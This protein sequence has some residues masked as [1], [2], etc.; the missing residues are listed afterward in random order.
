MTEHTLA[1]GEPAAP[2]RPAL[3]GGPWKAFQISQ[4]TAFWGVDIHWAATT[5]KELKGTVA[6]QENL[7]FQN[8]IFCF[9]TS[10]PVA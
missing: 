7:D 6:S 1:P 8:S 4:T 3:P 5:P 9:Q 10:S 2:W